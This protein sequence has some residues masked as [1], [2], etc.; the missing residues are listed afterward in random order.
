V[1]LIARMS[2]KLTRASSLSLLLLAL[3][4]L[5]PSVFAQ[6]AAN[7]KISGLSVEQTRLLSER[8][9]LFIEYQASQQWQK[10][11]DLLSSLTTRAL[12]RKDYVEV[13]TKAYRDWGRAPVLEFVPL[14]IQSLQADPKEKMWIIRGC[15]VVSEKGERAGKPAI[16]E[17]SWEKSNWFFSEIHEFMGENTGDPCAIDKLKAAPVF[18]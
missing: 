16:I 8:L 2:F 5:T 1:N 15:S 13:T 4:S 12:T 3:V 17:A 18:D 9:R 6:A 11:Y 14:T 7:E 10:Q